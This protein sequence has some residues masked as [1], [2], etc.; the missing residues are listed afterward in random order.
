MP[1]IDAR[2]YKVLLICPNRTV[3]TEFTPLLSYGLPLA[4][5]HA[6]DIYPNRRDIM[7][8]LTTVDPKIC[9][10]DF[11]NGSEAI[12]VLSELHQVAHQLPVIAL[13][14]SDNPDLVLQCLRQGASDFLIRPITTEQLDA[15]VEKVARTMPT[16]SRGTASKVISVMPAKGSAGATTVACNL[17]QQCKRLTGGDVLLADMDPLTGTIS[18]LLKLKSTYSFMDVLHRQSSLEADLW[19]QMMATS[20]GMDV[21]L[22]PET[23]VDAGVELSTAAPVVEFAQNMYQAVVLDCGGVYGSWNLSL[24]RL[25]DEVLLV[26][27]NE[28]ASLDATQRAL[29]YMDSQRVEM[30]KVK[31]VVN[32]Y[33]KDFG[34]QSEHL[35]QAFTTEIFHTLPA[36]NDAVQK[37]LLDGKPIQSGT[38]FGKSLAAMAE[39]LIEKRAAGGGKK[40]NKGGGGLLSSFWR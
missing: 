13:L 6:L 28:L 32:R 25:A 29:M 31:V 24:A 23:L 21:L 16:P 7:T 33:Q 37:S 27:T 14:A 4:P 40:S 10:L 35:K 19:K 2:Y 3:T 1:I 9:F 34:L 20:Q 39:R 15:C 8:V 22:S 12:S 11:S 5:V 26:T 30:G 18:F 17:A 38:Q 36:D